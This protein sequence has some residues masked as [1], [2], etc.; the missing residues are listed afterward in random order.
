MSLRRSWARLTAI[1]NRRR[2]DEELEDDIRVHLAL[3][4]EEA[5]AQGMPAD[6]AR[7]EARRQFGG[8]AQ[9]KEEH[10][11][12]R[13]FRFLETMAKD[14]RYGLAGLWR[15]PGFAVVVIGVLGLGIGGTVAMFSVVDAVLLKPLPFP[16]P[17]RIVA[18]W[19]APR[20]GVVNAVS[21]RQ[22]LAWQRLSREFMTLT[23]EQDFSAAINY[24]NQP[25]RLAGKRVTAD[26]FNVFGTRVALGRA[27]RSTEDQPGA[28][29]VVVL[30]HSAWQTHFGGDPNILQKRVALDG[31]SYQVIGVL[32]P[33]AFDRDE[34][35]FWTPLLFD[36][37]E[38]SS[39]LKWLTLY[40]RVGNGLSIEQAGQKMQAIY[41][42]LA[43]DSSMD[44]DKTYTAVVRPLSELLLGNNLQRSIA[45]AFGAVVLVLLIACANVANL[46]FVRGASRKTEL[47]V[48]AALGAGRGR[49]IGQL[50]TECLMLC[51]LGGAAAVAI[52][53]ALIRAA[54]P[55][56]AD[57]LPFTA[58]VR[59]NG[60][61][62][63]FAI[64]VVLGVAL[65]TGALPAWYTSFS[66]LADALKQGARGFS[67]AHWRARRSIVICEVALSLVLVCGALLLLRS[68]LNLQRVDAGV[69]IE[70]VV[71][72][73]VNL[74]ADAYGTPEKAAEFYGAL[75]RRLQAT[76]GVMK[77]GMA[78][79][80]P[81]H[82]ISNGE[83][84]FIPGVEKPVLIRFKRVDSGYLPTLDIPL[85]AGRGIEERDRQAGPRVMLINQALAKRLAD[86][87]GIQE[88]IGAVVR[89]TGSDYS[90]QTETRTDVQIV[91]VIRNERTTSPGAAEP[92]VVYV[93]LAQ[94]PNPNLKILIR[95]PEGFEAVMP[96]IRQAVRDVDPNLPLGEVATMQEI[97][98]ETLSGVSRPAGLI[99]AFA[100]IALLLAG[101]GLYG[102]IAYSLTQRR[103]EFGIRMA[104]GA[105]PETVF[106]QVLRGAL[107]MVGAG[108]LLG[109]AGTYAMTR[110]LTSFLFEVSPLDPFS[111]LL[112]CAALTTIGLAAAL[113]PARRAARVDPMLTLREEG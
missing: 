100:G 99:A 31:R 106:L 98:A 33:G 102:V 81:L 82:W 57:S 70:N 54:K 38:K 27:F 69:R 12:R 28:E 20:P 32:E 34:A 23:A 79:V 89:L 74:P 66:G 53:F 52:A 59:L 68:L 51:A 9:M 80:L 61:A 64:V 41:S 43:E 76:P 19:E 8:I 5:A 46:L 37:A 62:L 84:I 47:A 65:L 26:Y 24:N 95:T 73:S 17:D 14:L 6:A 16:A 109:L 25:I 111:L 85:L 71:T 29:P 93:P 3:A 44:G 15:A 96:A 39:A 72:T 87:A 42:A 40:G 88:P 50:L 77:A 11:D 91:G 10:Y 83:G 1:W 103:K 35:Q 58:E 78:T 90:G 2:L 48:R 63:L 101:V 94:V 107:A 36:Q 18:V 108:L 105:K 104:L 45:V 7:L 113:I 97:K 30:S 75:A 55:V 56:L 92:P 110:I 67:G 86:V 22:F 49:L 60:N 13:S 112:G 4:E 21:V